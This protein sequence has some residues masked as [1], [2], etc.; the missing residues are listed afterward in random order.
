MNP[1]EM[2]KLQCSTSLTD[3]QREVA[4][5]ISAQVTSEW[6]ETV[7]VPILT[8]F[9]RVS[10]RVMDW[11]VTNYTKKHC[12][13]YLFES[14]KSSRM[15]HV[16]DEYNEK[17]N[18]QGRRLFDPFRRGPRVFFE[19]SDG[20]MHESTLGQIFFWHWADVHGVLK[21]LEKDLHAVEKHQADMHAESQKRKRSG[22]R[23]RTSLTRT[24]PNVCML[25]SVPTT[26]HFD[27]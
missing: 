15:F 10:I 22:K 20:L 25:F 3:R 5:A 17:C 19:T 13:S 9:H 26:H 4:D 1:Q 2:I 24:T 6:A 23:K 11:Y 21:N 8:G 7:L 18:A 16:H 27:D 14:E 12:T